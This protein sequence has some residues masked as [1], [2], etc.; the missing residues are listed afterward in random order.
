MIYFVSYKFFQVF[1]IFLFKSEDLSICTFS[2]LLLF[3][4][5]FIRQF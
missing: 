4:V 1:I 3:Y 5:S 2:M